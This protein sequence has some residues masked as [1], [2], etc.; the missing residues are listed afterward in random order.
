MNKSII[1]ASVHY[2]GYHYVVVLLSQGYRCGFVGIKRG[3]RFYK[4]DFDSIPVS[5][6]GGLTYAGAE[7]ENVEAR[8]TWW[9]GFDCGH[10]EDGRDI[11]AVRQEF[12]DDPTVKVMLDFYEMTGLW[13]NTGKEIRSQNF[14]EEQ[15]RDI[16]RQLVR[17]ESDAT[18]C[19]TKNVAAETT[20]LLVLCFLTG[21][22]NGHHEPV[23][24][25]VG[26]ASDLSDLED[27]FSSYMEAQ[28]GE[29]LT[30]KEITFDV[31]YASG[32]NWTFVGD[33]PIHAD[34]MRLLWL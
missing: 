10:P 18:T 25:L 5:C 12:A 2:R 6:H 11:Q 14:V 29:G 20:T 8:D 32:R 17:L 3:H 30:P 22:H 19:S 9:I 33:K 15:C 26:G 4:K 28:C 27:S 13:D 1:E 16:V 31:M 23:S 21:N 7:L 24:I 34:A